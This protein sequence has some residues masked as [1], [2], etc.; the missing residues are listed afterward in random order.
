MEIGGSMKYIKNNI[1]KND[2]KVYYNKSI[3]SSNKC[4]NFQ[5]IGKANKFYLH[6]SGYKRYHY[7]FCK[8]NDDTIVVAKPSEIKNGRVR[9]PNHPSI[10]GVGFLGDGD[11]DFYIK[12]K[13]TKQYTLFQN[14]I[15][16]CYNK[17]TKS[18]KDY[19]R[20]G[21]RLDNRLHD[22]QSFC[23]FISGLKNY[24]AWLLDTKK[25]QLD[26]DVLCEKFNI[27]PKVYSNKTCLFLTAIDNLAQRNKKPRLT[28]LIYVGTKNGKK[29]EFDNISQFA[30]D[31]NLTDTHIGRCAKGLAKKH[32]G[33]IFSVKN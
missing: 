8:F 33:W 21:V 16:R 6:T 27:H 31:H 26:K 17:N 4:G 28:G 24:N 30:R 19:G 12:Q 7:Y 14:I 10:C 18:Y 32:K 22:F 1:I 15:N 20:L 29:Y 13:P 25:W 2:S 11:W 3:W 9:N 23:N 5:I